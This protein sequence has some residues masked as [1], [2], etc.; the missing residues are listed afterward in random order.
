MERKR[1]DRF[2]APSLL[3][4]GWPFLSLNIPLWSDSVAKVPKCSA[5]HFTLRDETSGG[6]RHFADNDLS[7]AG[8]EFLRPF[9][10]LMREGADLKAWL[11]RRS[12]V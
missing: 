2:F 11:N 8:S 10:D 9:I 3:D 6:Q 4:R 12:V 5:A 1:A 7:A